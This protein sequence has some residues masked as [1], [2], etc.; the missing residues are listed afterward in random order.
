MAAMIAKDRY[1]ISD[2]TNN[3]DN[4]DYNDP[5]DFFQFLK[6]RSNNN[7]AKVNDDGILLKEFIL[8]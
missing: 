6:D 4:Y 8:H 1:T 5:Y 2:L 7:S 3:G